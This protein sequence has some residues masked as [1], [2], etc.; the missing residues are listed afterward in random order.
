[1]LACFLELVDDGSAN[2]DITIWN[3]S[4]RSFRWTEGERQTI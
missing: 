2:S 4:V 3:L 1:M